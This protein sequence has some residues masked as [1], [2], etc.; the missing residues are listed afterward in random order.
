MFASATHLIAASGPAGRALFGTDWSQRPRTRV[1]YCG[2]NFA[3]FATENAHRERESARR[4]FGIARDEIV[5]G[6]VGSFNPPKNH[7]FLAAIVAAAL[8]RDPRVCVFCVGAGPLSKSLEAQFQRAG[9][10]AIFSGL[11]SDVP[12]LLRAMDVF[13]FPSLYEGLPLA[14]VE[15]QA[16]GL[17]CVVSTE[18]TREVDVVPGLIRWLPLAAG[19]GVWADAVLESACQPSQAAAGLLAMRSSTFSVEASFKHLRSIYHSG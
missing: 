12:R 14:L 9:V 15:A 18:V 5:L 6:H 1:L 3:P 17:P 10:R 19:A 13:V 4:E 11:R 7:A 16:A 2:L 8:D